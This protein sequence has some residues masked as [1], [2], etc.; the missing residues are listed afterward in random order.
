MSHT[1]YKNVNVHSDRTSPNKSLTITSQ[2]I[3]K[4]Y[5]QHCLYWKEEEE[6]EEEEFCGLVFSRGLKKLRVKLI[7][8][9]SSNG[10]WR[11]ARSLTSTSSVMS[12]G[13]S[14]RG[15]QWQPVE[16]CWTPCP[17]GLRQ[18]WKIMV[19]RFWIQLNMFLVSHHHYVFTQHF[20]LSLMY[21]SVYFKYSEVLYKVKR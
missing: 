2:C 8:G 6:E 17:R 15:L 7:C 3:F 9:A 12:S 1:H 16:L 10:R 14:G 5:F 4:C 18:C 21:H 11:S 19:A 13:R 20:N